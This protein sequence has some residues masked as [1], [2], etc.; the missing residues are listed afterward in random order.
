MLRSYVTLL[1]IP[2]LYGF[3]T[4]QGQELVKD[5]RRG[6][7]GSDIQSI[8]ALGNYVFFVA[9]DS[10]HGLEL[11]RSTVNGT[12]HLVKDIKVGTGDAFSTFN[13]NQIIAFK[14]AIYFAADDG[15]NGTELWR[16]NGTAA[17]TYMLKNINA[18]ASSTP[19][20]FFV[21]GNTLYFSA[22]EPGSGYELWKTDGTAAGT[23]LVKDI[24]DGGGFRGSKPAEFTPFK[25]ELYFKALNDQ[26][27]NQIWK[28]DGTTAG[29]V[30][31]TK[32][33][34]DNGGCSPRYLQATDSNLFFAASGSSGANYDHELWMLDNSDSGATRVKNISR[35]YVENL[36]KLRMKLSRKLLVINWTS[37]K[38]S[39]RRKNS[40]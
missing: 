29:T 38:D 24:R 39:L 18:S 23:V 17:G 40:T 35:V 30:Q 37:N 11:W 14:S 36:R 34:Q 16:S 25:G 22:Y 5:I 27:G 20:T 7:L 3:Q 9:N 21:M 1:L 4:L 12:P 26:T 33:N 28:T 31:V 6:K 19:K 13:E 32:I 15:T 10:T 2:L 8:A